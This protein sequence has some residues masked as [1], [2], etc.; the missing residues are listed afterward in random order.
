MSGSD[1]FKS[2]AAML[3]AASLHEPVDHFVGCRGKRIRAALLNLSYRIAGGRGEVPQEISHAIEWLHAGSLV[4]DDV[5]D[6]S[7]LRR[8]QPTMH[9][10]LGMPLAVNAGNFMYFRA[11]EFITASALCE[12]MRCRLSQEL[13]RIARVCHEG[14]ALDLSARLDRL[15]AE[16]WYAIAESISIHKT[17]V[18]VELSMRMGAIAAGCNQHLEE[19]LGRFG[20]QIGVALQMRNDLDE[21]SSV[22]EDAAAGRELSRVDDLKNGRVTWPWAWLSKRTSD[23]DCEKLAAWLQE[24]LITG[25][26]S[27]LGQIASELLLCVRSHGQEAI[28]RQIEEPLRLLGEH[29]IDDSSLDSLREVLSMIDVSIGSSDQSSVTRE[30]SCSDQHQMLPRE[31]PS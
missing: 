18:L 14:Q 13:V 3:V 5:Q 17:G 4:I 28:K 30:V 6:G 16:D 20:C 8:G 31:I 7:A 24:S 9:Q 10:Q 23:A 2:L 11:M 29:V 27:T 19:R 22:A 25:A 15:P 12:S 1:S 26:D 21:L